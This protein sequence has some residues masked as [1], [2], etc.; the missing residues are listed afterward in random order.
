MKKIEPARNMTIPF[1]HIFEVETGEA[2]MTQSFPNEIYEA[3]GVKFWAMN[4][5]AL[6][7]NGVSLFLRASEAVRLT[8]R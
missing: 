3:S 2:S 8:Y 5:E 4:I 7:R 1:L 6:N